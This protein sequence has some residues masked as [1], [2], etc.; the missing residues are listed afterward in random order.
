[1]FNIEESKIDTDATY[2]WMDIED[3]FINYVE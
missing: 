1:M 3:G 2:E